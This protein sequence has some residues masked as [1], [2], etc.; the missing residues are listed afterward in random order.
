MSDEK[1]AVLLHVPETLLG[2]VKSSP[3]TRLAAQAFAAPFTAASALFS[4][5]VS[6][7]LR[8]WGMATPEI[9]PS[10][11]NMAKSSINVNPFIIE[12]LPRLEAF[13][14]FA[15]LTSLASR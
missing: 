6:E 5:A 4:R 9:I 3:V 13:S 12:L 11:I 14:L 2:L 1:T 15:I 8:N 10:M 7:T